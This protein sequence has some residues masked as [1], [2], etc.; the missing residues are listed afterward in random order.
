MASEWHNG[1]VIDVSYCEQDVDSNTFKWFPSDR[2]GAIRLLGEQSY[3]R[4]SCM[5]NRRWI[6][7]AFGTR[8]SF[9]IPWVLIFSLF[10]PPF[11]LFPFSFWFWFLCPRGE[12]NDTAPCNN[13]TAVKWN[14]KLSSRSLLWTT[15]TIHR[16]LRGHSDIIPSRCFGTDA[17]KELGV[18]ERNTRPP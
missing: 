3:V 1:S 14:A 6:T 10:L 13:K 16:K 2:I 12:S 8:C 17:E 7:M 4:M 11:F 18:A 5:D 9:L 15:T